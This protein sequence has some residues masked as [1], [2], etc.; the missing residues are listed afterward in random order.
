METSIYRDTLSRVQK[1]EKNIKWDSVNL[2]DE[3]YQMVIF[4]RNL[5]SELKDYVLRNG[6]SEV[7]KE[8]EFFKHIKPQIL[9]KLVFYN[10][11]SRI[12]T[13]CPATKGTMYHS[14]YS[15]QLDELRLEYIDHVCNSEFYRYYRSGRVDRDNVFFRLGN[16]NFYDG[17]NSFV[18]EID[19][20]F[21]TYY[22]YK[23]ARII[24]NELLYDYLHLKIEPYD[25]NGAKLSD[26][27]IESADIYWT[28]TKIALIELLYALHVSGCIA[29]GANGRIGLRSL[30]LLF[31]Q[32]FGVQLGDIH[33]AFH[34]MKDRVGDRTA[35]ITHLKVCLEQYMDKN[36]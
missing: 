4:L 6:F 23:I 27:S 2:I 22:D 31:Q 18:F 32:I 26:I 17:L 16:I 14:Y 25:T 1:E 35:F 11:I 36:I 19:T 13:A 10:K 21:S 3:S 30:A 29:H 5:L 24:A 12:E 8:I 28:E 34:R 9:G 20:H 7:S 33:H 15:H